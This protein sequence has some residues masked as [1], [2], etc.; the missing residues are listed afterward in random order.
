MMVR[1][2]RQDADAL[3]TIAQREETSRQ[4]IVRRAVRREI[5]RAAG[6]PSISSR[7]LAALNAMT[8][9]DMAYAAERAKDRGGA[10]YIGPETAR[11]ERGSWRRSGRRLTRA[12][13][14]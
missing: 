12:R 14:R 3:T 13:R 9:E 7:T 11:R 10:R 1:V 6:A 4:E 5:E 8:P 2:T